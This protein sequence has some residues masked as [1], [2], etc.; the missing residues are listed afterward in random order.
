MDNNS[1]ERAIRNPVVGRKVYYGSGSIWSA[2]LAAMMFTI[3]QTVILWKLNPRTWTRLY[4]ECCAQNGGKAPDDLS[5]F[6]PWKM[7]KDRLQQLSQPP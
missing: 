7:S 1:A 2:A 5:A 4:L 6:L 3:F